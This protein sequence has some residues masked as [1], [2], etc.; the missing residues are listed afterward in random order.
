MHNI[1]LWGRQGFSPAH[2][3]PLY[4]P[5]IVRARC[6][7]VA[8]G[9]M[10]SIMLGILLDIL[11]LP[12]VF[13]IS[14]EQ[15]LWCAAGVGALMGAMR[16]D[17]W[18]RVG[19][20][21][22]TVFFLGV[23][24]TPAMDIAAK[25]LVRRDTITPPVDAILV[26]LGGVNAAGTLA[27]EA[28]DRLLTGLDLHKHQAAADFAITRQTVTR[29]H[30]TVSSATDQQWLI[31]LVDERVHVWH[32]DGVRTTHDEVEKLFRLGQRRGWKH[33]VVVTSPWHTRRACAVFERVGFQVMCLPSRSSDV[34]GDT[35]HERIALF[36]LWLHETAGW[37]V[38]RW[39]GWV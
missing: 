39:R 29:Q 6:I 8:G 11:G 21:A 16:H 35:P 4:I 34:A 23:A 33:V 24:F 10:A 12:D 30:H 19:L 7:A 14:S 5:F 22:V 18:L 9:V 17:A 25:R 3:S 2:Y 36:R 31:N 20:V 15:L 32:V 37:W 38:Y 28:T 27:P 1:T 26:L 13:K